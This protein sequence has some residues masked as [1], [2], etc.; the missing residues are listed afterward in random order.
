MIERQPRQNRTNL[1]NLSI[2]FQGNDRS[3][4]RKQ[5]LVSARLFPAELSFA[6]HTTIASVEMSAGEL[7]GKE[8]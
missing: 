2:H 1:T 4:V 6:R 3:S 5:P 8:T 7:R